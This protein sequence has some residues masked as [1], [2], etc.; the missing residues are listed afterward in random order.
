MIYLYRKAHFSASHRLF[1]PKYSD[2]ENFRVFG[3]CANPAGHGHNYVIEVCVKGI[4]DPATGFV[5]DLK[6]LKTVIEEHFIRFVDHK[7]LNVDVLFMKDIIPSSEN[8]AIQCWKQLSPHIPN[9]SLHSIRLY[10]TEKN[11]VEY[12]G[13]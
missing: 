5:V 3:Q 10:E 2:E 13:D 7:N 12:F 11:F 6:L 1:D 4:P 8:I 9:G